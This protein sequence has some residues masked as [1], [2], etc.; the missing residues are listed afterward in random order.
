MTKGK[1]SSRPS[2]AQ[3]SDVWNRWKAGQT[4]DEIGRF[5]GK[6]HNSI[7]KVVLPRG[8]IPSITRRHSRLALR[9]TEPEDISRG[10][11]CGS[12]IREIASPRSSRLHSEPGG[13]SATGMPTHGAIGGSQRGP[14]PVRS[15]ISDQEPREVISNRQDGG[16]ASGSWRRA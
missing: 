10:I 2:P 6:W 15:A 7:R 9:L 5:Y 12:S 4:L 3:K 16:G 14:R 8:G 1:W 13:R 11:A